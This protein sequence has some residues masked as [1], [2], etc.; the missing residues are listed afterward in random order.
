MNTQS[1]LTGI[2]GNGLVPWLQ[3]VLATKIPRT[4]EFPEFFFCE[5]EFVTIKNNKV[6]VKKNLNCFMV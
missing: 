6:A 3:G 1:A 2:P 5:Q 4:E